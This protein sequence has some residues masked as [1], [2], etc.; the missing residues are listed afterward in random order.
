MKKNNKKIKANMKFHFL[1]VIQN[2]MFV[3]IFHVCFYG[4]E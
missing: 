2:F 3:F 4:Q 1:P